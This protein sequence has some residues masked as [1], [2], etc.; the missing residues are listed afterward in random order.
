MGFGEKFEK[1]VEIMR[2]LRAPDGCPWDQEQTH[3]SLKK[4]AIEESYELCDAIDSGEDEKIK[5]ELGDVLLQV[6][7]HAE[8]AE[9]EGRF[10]VGDSIDYVSE[11]MVNRHPHVFGDETA[12]TAEDVLRRWEHRKLE[13]KK[14]GTSILDGVPKALPALL[15]AHMIQQRVA[16]VGFDWEKTED[17]LAKVREELDE[18]AEAAQEGDKAAVEEEL[19]DLLFAVVNVARWCEAD[20]E[21]ALSK[22]VRKFRRRFNYIEK[23]VHGNGNTLEGTS[24][25]EMDRLWEQAKGLPL[26]EEATPES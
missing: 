8:I 13:E 18:L 23:T 24:L 15:R 17:V 4:Y 12:A 22:T 19:G 21:N 5:E 16:R 25:E 26:E 9:E 6:V 20:P 7:F 3:E 14:A 10:N 11:K 1:L 2:R